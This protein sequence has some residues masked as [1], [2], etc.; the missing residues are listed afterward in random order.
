MFFG[1]KAVVGPCCRCSRNYDPE[2]DT[3]DPHI[4]VSKR[5]HHRGIDGLFATNHELGEEVPANTYEYANPHQTI[6]TKCCT[7]F[8]WSTVAVVLRE[9]MISA[10]MPPS[11]AYFARFEP[12]GTHWSNVVAWKSTKESYY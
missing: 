7:T 8:R 3:V 6:Q 5:H 10:Q 9:S 2:G 12:G 4:N 1:M 11:S